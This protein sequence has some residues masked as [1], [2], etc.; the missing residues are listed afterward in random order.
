MDSVACAKVSRCPYRL[1]MKSA[2][3]A[4]HIQLQSNCILS[5]L[6]MHNYSCSKVPIEQKVTQKDRAGSNNLSSNHA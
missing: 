5:I 2:E 4:V 1:T 3:S 6:L